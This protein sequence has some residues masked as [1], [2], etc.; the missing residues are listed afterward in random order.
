MAEAVEAWGVIKFVNGLEQR[1]QCPSMNSSTGSWTTSRSNILR[2]ALSIL[3]ARGFKQAS[4][5][6][7]HGYSVPISS[8][9]LLDYS[10]RR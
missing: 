9:L 8:T 5:W 2:A 3:C 10:E 1:A 6:L 7:L 4:H